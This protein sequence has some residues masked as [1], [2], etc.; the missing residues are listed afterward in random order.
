MWSFEASRKSCYRGPS[1]LRLDVS[2]RHHRI[3]ADRCCLQGKRN[4][5]DHLNGAQNGQLKYFKKTRISTFGAASWTRVPSSSSATATKSPLLGLTITSQSSRPSEMISDT[6]PRRILV[7]LACAALN[8]KQK[9]SLEI[10]WR[11][12]QL[13]VDRSQCAHFGEKPGGRNCH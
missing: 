10:S 7:F 6:D 13:L 12:S 3:K 11:Y 9:R 2:G 4:H 8:E 5:F 1:S